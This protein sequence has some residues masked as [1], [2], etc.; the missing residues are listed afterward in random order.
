MTAGLVDRLSSLRIFLLKNRNILIS[1]HGQLGLALL[2]EQWRILRHS[3]EHGCS[4]YEKSY[5]PN[6][7]KSDNPRRCTGFPIV[8]SRWWRVGLIRVLTP[9]ARPRRANEQEQQSEWEE[10]HN[11]YAEQCS[12]TSNP[13]IWRAAFRALRHSPGT[14]SRGS[15]E[16]VQSNSPDDFPGGNN[17]G[18]GS[19][20]VWRL[21]FHPPRI[22]C[23]PI[24]YLNLVDPSHGTNSNAQ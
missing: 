7:Q 16:F 9:D 14:S 13:T 20:R 21:D 17:D 10:Q 2:S 6:E 22:A 23:L 19:F 1:T 24:C 8:H 11:T 15:K 18:F 4:Y 5:E 3:R 12:T